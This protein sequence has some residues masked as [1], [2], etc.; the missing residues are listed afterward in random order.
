MGPGMMGQGMIG[1]GM[2]DPGM[3]GHG[4]MH[5]G[6][7]HWRGD[8]SFSADEIRRVIDGQIALRGLQR[9]KVGAVEAADDSTYTVDIVT[10]DDS[11]A[12][13]LTVDKATGRILS[14]E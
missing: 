14:M 11:L 9:L 1:P 8:R 4:M 7:G 6:V 2:M 12:L 3:M 13:R 5:G 10:S